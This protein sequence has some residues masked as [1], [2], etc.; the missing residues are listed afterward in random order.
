MAFTTLMKPDGRWERGW[1]A[2][3][4]SSLGVPKAPEGCTSGI[5]GAMVGVGGQGQE[6]GK[7]GGEYRG[8][9]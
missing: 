7:V 9:H 6:R 3:Q 1:N 8:A 2:E 4:Q 5:T